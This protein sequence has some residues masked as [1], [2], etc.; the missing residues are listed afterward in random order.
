MF[1]RF[2]RIPRSRRGNTVLLTARRV[3]KRRPGRGSAGSRQRLGRRKHAG[4]GRKS[5]RENPACRA[6]SDRR[7]DVACRVLDGLTHTSLAGCTVAVVPD[8][9]A[10]TRVGCMLGRV[11]LW[12]IR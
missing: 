8:Y 7:V 3:R 9:D 6:N 5:H 12:L 10:A 1:V 4:G 2:P 11:V